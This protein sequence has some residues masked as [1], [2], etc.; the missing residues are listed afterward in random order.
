MIKILNEAVRRV[1]NERIDDERGEKRSDGQ[2]KRKV[3]WLVLLSEAA[4]IDTVRDDKGLGR[5]ERSSNHRCEV[6]QAKSLAQLDHV[7][8]PTTYTSIAPRLTQLPEATANRRASVCTLRMLVA[9]S[10]A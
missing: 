2:R 6:V 3:T 8:S 10:S 1:E 5:G 7:P 9:R 4:L